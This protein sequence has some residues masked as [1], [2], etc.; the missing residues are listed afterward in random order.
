MY[1]HLNLTRPV[2]R[3]EGAGV[4]LQKKTINLILHRFKSRGLYKDLIVLSSYRFGRFQRPN[5]LLEARFGISLGIS[6]HQYE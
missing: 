4:G 6:G 1:F 3:I 5:Y 2:H